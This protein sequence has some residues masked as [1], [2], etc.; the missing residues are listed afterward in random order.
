MDAS[1]VS[2]CVGIIMELR[3]RIRISNGV[4][5][6][7]AKKLGGR[8]EKTGGGKE[9]HSPEDDEEEGNREDSTHHDRQGVYERTGGMGRREGLIKPEKG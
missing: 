9:V 7:I 5:Q 1:S 8:Y 6:K 4:R 2:L 3:R